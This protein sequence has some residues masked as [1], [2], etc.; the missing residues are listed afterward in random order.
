M[1]REEKFEKYGLVYC[2]IARRYVE[3]NAICEHCSEGI[4]QKEQR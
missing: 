3:C 2:P 1:T 4:S